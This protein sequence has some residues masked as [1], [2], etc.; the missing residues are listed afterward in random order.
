M[1]GIKHSVLLFASLVLLAGFGATDEAATPNSRS[2]ALEPKPW[3]TPARLALFVAQKIENA[4]YK[5]FAL[6]DIARAQVEAGDKGQALATLKQ[7]TQN[8]QKIEN[9][10]YKASVLRDIA[11]AQV[12]AGDKEQAL[13]TLKQALEVAQK[14]ERRS[15]KA[16]TL[17]RIASALVEA[18]DKEQAL[19]TLKQALEVAQ[20]IEEAINKASTL[21][22]H[23][24]GSGRG[25][26][27]ALEVAHASLGSGPED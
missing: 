4:D 9:A 6:W 26:R 8:T 2:N 7:A 22:G 12:E 24:L 13:A 15:S 11:S 19:T 18:G 5:A 10:Y 1:Q 16:R 17:G 27:E 25:G 21:S 3:D 14:I 23:C 20:K